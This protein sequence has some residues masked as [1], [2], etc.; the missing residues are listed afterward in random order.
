M[1]IDFKKQN[2]LTID[3]GDNTGWAFWQYGKIKDAGMFKINSRVHTNISDQYRFLWK[4]FTALANNCGK[5][6]FVFIEG[7]E[8]YSGSVK[9]I[10][11]AKKREGQAIPN[12]FKLAYLIGGYAQI[13]TQLS[14]QYKIITF[15][16]WGGNLSPEAVRAHVH[17]FGNDITYCSQHIYDAVLMGYYCIKGMI[18]GMNNDL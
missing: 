4:S 11:A 8:V 2:L 15:S 7:C 6:T 13:C 9:S 5:N 17:Q 14:L 16:A 12:L 1:K 10:T 18:K 3:P